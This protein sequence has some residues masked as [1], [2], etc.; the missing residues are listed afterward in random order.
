[1]KGN[2]SEHEACAKARENNR[3]RTHEHKKDWN[4]IDQSC[5]GVIGA[6]AQNKLRIVDAK[7]NFIERH[8]EEGN[9][10]FL[11]E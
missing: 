10:L 2:D 8:E 3:Q 5:E 9:I 11:N 1:M 7:C 4:E 6:F